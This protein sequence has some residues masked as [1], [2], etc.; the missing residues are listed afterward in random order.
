MP[1]DASGLIRFY[2]RFLGRRRF[3]ATRSTRLSVDS[4]DL[5]GAAPRPSSDEPPVFGLQPPQANS[6]GPPAPISH[7]AVN[8]FL[9]VES[10]PSSTRA[11]RTPWSFRQTVLLTRK[12]RSS[13]LLV[14]T[15]VGSVAVVIVW[16]FVAPIAETIAV[17]G[18]LE[19][20]NNT[21]RIDTPAPGV[22]EAVLVKE[23]Q[24]VSK[25][26]PLVRF[27]LREARSK[28]AASETVRQRLINENLIASATLGDPAAT[29]RL[30]VNQKRQL[31]SQAKEFSTR[32]E[33]ARQ[34]LLK[35]KVVLAGHREDLEIYT[36]IVQRYAELVKQGAASELQLIQAR[37]QQQ[38]AAND[39]AET[40]REIAKLEASLANTSALTNTDLRR[41]IEENLSEI[42][43]NDSDIRLAKL[44][45]QYGLLSAPVDGTVFDLE[46]R[47]GSVV[48]QGTG[49]SA[50]T[51]RKPLL[52]I[53]PFDALRARVYIPNSAVGFV[54][55]GLQAELSIDAFNA[56]DFGYVP[57]KVISIGSDALTAEEQKR[58][59]GT[60]ISGLYYPAVLKL[61]R[62]FIT[63]KSKN[64]PLQ[65][66]MTLTAD[67]KLRERRPINILF[68]FLEDQRRN[69]ERLR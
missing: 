22:V 20:D 40:R 49:L 62:Q 55:K 34:E 12:N 32:V 18:K 69:L 35:A 43:R 6:Q 2:E 68:S 47:P 15:A 9:A 46:V 48:A 30:S 63:L 29:A 51:E 11:P 5:V 17:Q 8:P 58:A 61:S 33:T 4:F 36:N 7:E 52:K 26:D 13:T 39:V 38:Q 10:S 53:V 1:A 31:V 19:A 16:A 28:L 44:Q 60:D 59:L 66:G 27:D 50:D 21:Q 25:G 56:S 54:S 3:S 23:G 67:I 64:V 65:S 42:A 14:W 24:R 41:K 57:A 45:I 37:Q